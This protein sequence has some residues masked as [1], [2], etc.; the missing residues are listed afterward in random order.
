MI[1]I[2]SPYSDPDPQTRDDRALLV[3]A[4]AIHC[5]KKGLIV[6]CPIA[7]WHTLAVLHDLPSGFLY[8]QRLNLGILRYCSEMY[9]LRLDGWDTSLGL[10]EEMQAAHKMFIPIRHYEAETFTEKL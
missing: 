3:G 9:V 8:W 5:V 7:S 2:G 6:Y 4:F 10:R 1:Y